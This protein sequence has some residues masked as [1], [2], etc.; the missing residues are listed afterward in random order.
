[1]GI[2]A[3]IAIIVVAGLIGGLIAQQFKQPLIL[4]YIL[5]GI[6][7]GPFTGGVTVSNIHDIE[8]LAEIGVALLLF[9]LGLE[10]SLKELRPVRHIALIGT[11]IQILLTMILGYG[12][13]QLLGWDWIESVWLGGLI[14]LSSTMVTLKTLMSQG[15]MGTLSS[16][17]MIGM[18]IVQDLAVVPLMIILPQLDQP[19]AGL[20][21]LAGAALKAA[22]FLFLMIFVGMRVIPK[23]M[24]YIANWNSKELFLLAITAIGLGVGYATY[25]FGL[26]F[27][28]GA[29]VAG[30]VLSESD[31]GHQALSDIIPVRDLFGLLFFVSVGML[32]DPVFL[33]ANWKIILVV[34]LLVAT[35]KGLIFG[36]ISRAFGYGNV[37]PLAVG[38]G[39]FQ[40]GEF[41]FV[42]ARV[43]IST[44]S[45]SNN[46]YAL[47]LAT[48][49]VTMVMTPVVSGLTAPLYALRKRWFKREPLQ[50][51]NLPEAGLH[52]HVV[53]AGGGRVGQYVAQVLQRLELAFVI[54]EIDHRR[55]MEAKDEGYS[56]IYGDAS[57][58]IVLEAARVN[59]ACLVLI[60]APALL[61][62]Q[63]IVDQVRHANPTVDIVA[64]AEG[65]EQM[66]V[67]RDRG[68]YEVIMPE[69]EAG[70]E[71]TRQA[72][73]HLNIPAT[74]IQ[75]FTDAI[76]RELYAPLYDS[77]DGY[78][79]IAQLQNVTNLLELNWIRLTAGSPFVGRTIHDLQIRS[80]TGVSVVG[81]I[82]DGEL[83]PNPD[84]GFC[85]A[86]GDLV[87]VLGDSQQ[88]AG[89]QALIMP[90][91]VIET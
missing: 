72:L 24:A 80:Q 23:V 65:V 36:G 66:Q 2:A 62:T 26:S 5:A 9:A 79:T 89:L 37:V 13:G 35:G 19:G 67:L 40:V 91:A 74:E 75:R 52:N 70:L 88:L 90:V 17:V 42:L 12:I 83:Y 34:V 4:G 55:V 16:R 27:A 49:I 61:S 7:V 31:Y 46:L 3:D 54:V 81:V 41:S 33:I 20:S 50:T 69:F 48:A 43:G 22:V 32:V 38:L 57:Q 60:T 1:M 21:V 56:V 59:Q 53:I 47:I 78:Q 86:I 6:I 8:L 82:R 73:L 64:R 14:A 10:F 25:L 87:A 77:N 39:L 68:V 76:R 63:A 45:I 44:N 51:M 58:E 30:M 29:F 15:R 71:I 28:F 18:L 11:P 84:A 85:F